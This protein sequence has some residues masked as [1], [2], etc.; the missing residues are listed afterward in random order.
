MNTSGDQEDL[1]DH[2][3]LQAKTLQNT[4]RIPLEDRP[5]LAKNLGK[6]AEML[7]LTNPLKGAR[8]MFEQSAQSKWDKRKRLLRLPDEKPSDPADHNVYEGSG[9]FYVLLAKEAG[10][11]LST[12][13]DPRAIRRSIRQA[14]RH[15]MSG[16]SFL[17]RHLPASP[18]EADVVELLHRLSEIVSSKV[19][20][21]TP[22]RD[23]WRLLDRTPIEFVSLDEATR[24][25]L[26]EV[27]GRSGVWDWASPAVRLGSV[28][29]LMKARMFVLPE[30]WATTVERE[31]YAMASEELA[32][33]LQAMGATSEQLPDVE[34]SEEA[35]WGWKS[36]PLSVVHAVDLVLAP[37]TEAHAGLQLEVFG[38]DGL[39]PTFVGEA[40]CVIS[41]MLVRD[42]YEQVCHDF[43]LG[44]LPV[45][46][47]WSPGWAAPD[48]RAR[49]IGFFDHWSDYALQPAC[50]AVADGW[51]EDGLIGDI[52]LSPACTFYPTIEAPDADGPMPCHE[53]SAA[54]A[55]LRNLE[56]ASVRIDQILIRHAELIAR[57]GFDHHARLITRYQNVLSRLEEEA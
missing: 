15:L 1:Q 5:V 7:N 14:L 9:Q 34:W 43:W 23:L 25:S 56:H 40:D 39:Y 11:L 20:E 3:W 54:A 53:K 30:E 45:K 50:G 38:E 28:A 36:M 55:I 37:T 22:I 4:A 29:R 2:I 27:V 12:S 33:W 26:V 10:R 51:V 46:A 18:G 52:L 47:L 35:G 49:L 17:P 8:R 24:A 44:D 41:E 32:A 16:T 31:P 13:D 57:A 48:G 19:L 21:H 42:A 6:L